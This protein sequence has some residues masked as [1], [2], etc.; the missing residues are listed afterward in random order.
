MTAS[1]LRLT[2]PVMTPVFLLAEAPAVTTVVN[3]ISHD[4]RLSPGL[5]ARISYTPAG[6]SDESFG[7][8]NPTIKVAVG[9]YPAFVNYW[10]GID[11]KGLPN[12]V[13]TLPRE[14]PPGPTTL[15]LINSAGTSPPFAIN[16]EAYSPALRTDGPRRSYCEARWDPSEFGYSFRLDAVGLEA[17]NPL[18]STLNEDGFGPWPPTAVTPTVTIGG[19]AAHVISSVLVLGSHG[20][21]QIL[22]APG[23]ETPQGLQ[24]ILLTIGGISSNAEPIVVGT[25]NALATGGLLSL[26]A[27]ESIAT[28]TGCS[29]SLSDGTLIGDWRNPVTNL[30]G[31]TV[32]VTD[33]VGVERLA[34][35]DYVSRLQVNYISPA[36]TANGP[37][38]VTISTGS[39]LLTI[40]P[41]EV[42]TVLAGIFRQEI[43][44]EG[45]YYPL[46]PPAGWIVRLRDGAQSYEP[47]RVDESGKIVPIDMGPASDQ[48]HLVMLGTG[49]HFRSSL[50]NVKVQIGEA[51]APVEYAG[52]QN[53][54]A[55]LDQL[56][57]LLPRSLKG[58]PSGD[59]NSPPLA[60]LVTVNGLNASPG[61][62]LR[63]K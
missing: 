22:V 26:V 43:G 32:K 9:G 56:N 37:G 49:F 58:S 60:V 55:G 35:I 28:A 27:P 2:V 63:F 20:F 10:G 40:S 36:G 46:R 52:P 17:T 30:A 38:T 18:I 29:R 1:L 51:S 12:V 15:T 3:M 62:V 8:G 25:T 23:Q 54:Y 24:S 61:T 44:N 4:T 16:L 21:Y 41:I 53:E 14:A 47:L 42:Y 6:P 31:T 50:D 59:L 39:G 33:S 13:V 34:P 57:V 19:A 7:P 5:L 48:L 45:E 11:A